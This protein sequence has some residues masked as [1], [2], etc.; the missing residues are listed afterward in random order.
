MKIALISLHTP[1][2]ENMR[3]ASALPYHLMK[4]RP[5]S[6]TVDIFSFNLNNVDY[7]LQKEIESELNTTIKIIPLSGWYSSINK[8]PFKVIKA[9]LKKPFLSYLSLPDDIAHSIQTNYDAI[10]TYGEDIEAISAKI[11]TDKNCVITTPDCEA[12][13]Y[14]RVLSLPSKIVSSRD[15]IKNS[16][17]YYKYLRLSRNFCTKKNRIFHLVGEEDTAF[18]KK[19]NPDIK[20]IFLPHPHYDGLEKTD[21]NFHNKIKLLVPGRYD[22]YAKEEFDIAMEVLLSNSDLASFYEITFLGKGFDSWNSKLV[23]A[24]YSSKIISFA[25][26]YNEELIK[27]DVQLSPITVGTGTK[28]KVLDAFINGLLVI[29]TLRALE[30]IQVDFKNDCVFY[31]SAEELL[32]HL[33]Q[34]PTNRHLYQQ[35][36]E[37][38]YKKV[39]QSHNPT[40]QSNNFFRLFHK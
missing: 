5:S 17:N 24:G 25:E 18:L 8:N 38:G 26:I 39:R 29:G 27:H 37:N 10:W 28:G 4:Y 2:K 21:F 13:F 40:L 15:F 20:A 3:G 36:R 34:I 19:I 32:D 33:R 31:Q 14:N 22:F 1:T 30:N 35:K 16:L 7:A 23:K 6:Y 11:A 9:F 12:L